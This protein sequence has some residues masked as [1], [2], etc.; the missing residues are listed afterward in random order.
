MY[1]LGK[2]SLEGSKIL[3]IRLMMHISIHRK[4]YFFQFTWILEI[5]GMFLLCGWTGM[6]RPA[7]WQLLKLQ[8]HQWGTLTTSSST[9]NTTYPV[10]SLTNGS[11]PRLWPRPR[12]GACIWRPHGG[13]V[14]SFSHG[15]IFFFLPVKDVQKVL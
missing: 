14:L 4:L 1:N 7:G 6:W 13:A 15:T 12:D 5:M 8:T 3:C 10:Q 2:Q 11:W 9:V